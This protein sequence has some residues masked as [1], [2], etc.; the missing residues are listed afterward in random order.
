MCDF[1]GG[2]K[3]H[4]PALFGRE[5]GYHANELG[6]GDDRS[7]DS[8]SN[9]CLAVFIGACEQTTPASEPIYASKIIAVRSADF[10]IAGVLGAATISAAV[11]EHSMSA[12]TREA[13]AEGLVAAYVTGAGNSGRWMPLPLT[14]SVSL[15]TLDVTVTMSYRFSVGKAAVT[16]TANLPASEMEA[17]I[18]AAFE[19]YR[20][21]ITVGEG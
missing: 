5:R 11:A 8:R 20:V 9:L 21:R 14:M 3:S 4:G 19:G 2:L 7:S 10:A 18:R 1:H 13:I 16:V 12:I 15:G 6:T 17:L